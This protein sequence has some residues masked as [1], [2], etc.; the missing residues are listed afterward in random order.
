MQGKD[1]QNYDYI[2]VIAK[3]ENYD[4][5]ILGYSDFLWTETEKVEDRKF[6]DLYNIT[7]KRK[8]RILFKDRLQLLQVDFEFALNERAQLEYKKHSRS[9]MATLITSVLTIALLFGCGMLVF[10]PKLFFSVLGCVLGVL[11]CT[12]S[13]YASLL[14]KKLYNKENIVFEQKKQDFNQKID[15]VLQEVKRLTKGAKDEK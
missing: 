15:D 13:V 5:I 6:H 12:A 9:K 10:L 11:I 8:H 3:K 1:Y 7:F 2:K 4:E 14:I